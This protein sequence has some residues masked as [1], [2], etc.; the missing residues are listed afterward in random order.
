M[1]GGDKITS[2]GFKGIPKKTIRRDSKAENQDEVIVAIVPV[3]IAEA[4]RRI[5]EKGGELIEEREGEGK[6]DDS[7][8]VN[9]PECIHSAIV[10]QAEGRIYPVFERDDPFAHLKIVKRL[11]R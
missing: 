6:D 5:F 3:N 4:M 7:L 8:T 11:K 1:N 10:S 9:L 2:F